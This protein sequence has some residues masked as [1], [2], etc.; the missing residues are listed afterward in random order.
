MRIIES[1][2]DFCLAEVPYDG[3]PILINEEG[4]VIEPALFFLI[5]AC[6]HR[7]RVASRKTWDAYGQA[8]YDYFGFL[9]STKQ[10]WDQQSIIGQ[11]SIVARY[12][13]WALNHNSSQTV[14]YRLRLIIRFYQ[15]AVHEKLIPEPPFGME[16]IAAIR[17][18]NGFLAHAKRNES[19][20]SADVL[21][22][23]KRS[24]F[25]V[26][27]TTQ[28]G[29]V[30]ASVQDNLTHE[31]MILLALQTG[32]RRSEIITVPSKYIVNTTSC[33]AKRRVYEIA[34]SASDMNLKG[35][36]PRTIHF[37]KA[38]MDRLWQYCHTYRPMLV[39]RNKGIDR[40]TLFL[41]VDGTP[42]S[43]T[44]IGKLCEQISRR[45]GFHLNCHMLRHTYATHTLHAL[46]QTLNMGNALLYV[47]ERLGH[48]SIVTT[49]KYLHYLDQ[50]E[51]D[52]MNRYQEEIDDLFVGR[53]AA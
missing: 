37:S 4:S 16:E 5:H 47:R 42:Y 18:N 40:A 29:Q 30:V 22:R 35:G 24:V 31:L 1:T 53:V 39:A 15:W 3:F 51:D 17:S 10:A 52:V 21:L 48:S 32:L 12:R 43:Y 20:F 26:L 9:E 49:Q 23:E 36:Q 14:N 34:L 19:T 41:T 28:A 2:E 7:G 44:G 45:V 25:K 6:I 38:L 46:R 33:N 27:S 11:P 50:I 13:D 8:M